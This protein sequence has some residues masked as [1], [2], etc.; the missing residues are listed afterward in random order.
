MFQHGDFTLF[1]PF[2]LETV[3]T[4]MF[5]EVDIS[6]GIC[7]FIFNHCSFVRCNYTIRLCATLGLTNLRLLYFKMRHFFFS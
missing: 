2:Y 5:L 4:V 6:A 3:L 7:L 1:N